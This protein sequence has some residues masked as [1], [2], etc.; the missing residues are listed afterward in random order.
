MDQCINAISS[1]HNVVDQWKF[2][3]TCSPGWFTCLGGP[4]L[5]VLELLLTSAPLASG[6]GQLSVCLNNSCA[7]YRNHKH[8]TKRLDLLHAD[9]T[10]Y[11]FTVKTF[12]LYGCILLHL[13]PFCLRCWDWVQMYLATMSIYH[14][15]VAEKI[16]KWVHFNLQFLMWSQ[17][18]QIRRLSPW[19]AY[20]A[21]SGGRTSV[22]A[23]GGRFYCMLSPAAL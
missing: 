18:A 15:S 5:A 14:T 1:C 3:V 21:V 20:A 11:V 4:E 8:R 6:Q 13:F 22:L 23:T 17:A 16:Q 7:I 12:V 2:I 10:W 9:V 19:C